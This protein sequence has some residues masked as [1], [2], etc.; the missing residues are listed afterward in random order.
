MHDDE[1]C[2]QIGRDDGNQL[3]VG[4]IQD[5]GQDPSGVLVGNQSKEGFLRIQREA[6]Q[7]STDHLRAT[8]APSPPP[9][10]KDRPIS[11]GGQYCTDSTPACVLALAWLGSSAVSSR[12]SCGYPRVRTPD[13]SRRPEDCAPA[14]AHIDGSHDRYRREEFL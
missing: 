10:G 14:V 9:N 1:R 6:I 11:K 2:A 13:A 7:K 5:P 4:N 12:G 3:Y 8:I